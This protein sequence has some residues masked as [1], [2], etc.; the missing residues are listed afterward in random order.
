VLLNHPTSR[1]VTIK[2]RRVV[3]LSDIHG[4][5][6]QETV[7][8][9]PEMLTQKASDI[10]EGPIHFNNDESRGLMEQSLGWS[11]IFIYKIKKSH[12]EGL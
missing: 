11:D 2:D 3:I 4:R 6:L 5:I 1:V 12:T 10:R 7:L 8:S 9:G